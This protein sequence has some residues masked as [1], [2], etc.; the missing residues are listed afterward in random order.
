MAQLLKNAAKSILKLF[1]KPP[2]KILRIGHPLLRSKG[3][4]VKPA[5]LLSTTNLIH[6]IANDMKKVFNSSLTPVI[7]LSANQLGHSTRM[8]AY[9]VKDQQVLKEQGLKEAIPI[10][11]LINP[12][13]VSSSSQTSSEYE[14]CESV[15]HYSGLRIMADP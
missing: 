13:I 2:P 1:V 15:P 11:F 12:V 9:Q 7:G 3:V 10:T 6:D 5:E 14:F 4:S 8:I